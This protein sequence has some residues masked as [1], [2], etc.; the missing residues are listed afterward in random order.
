[1]VYEAESDLKSQIREKGADGK[2]GRDG[3]EGLVSD[4][5]GYLAYGPYVDKLALGTFRADF[6]LKVDNNTID[7]DV[8]KIDV[9]N[10][11]KDQVLAQ[12]TIKCTDFEKA[13]FTQIFSLYFNN[14]Q[15]NDVYEFRT[16]Y[17]GNSE[18]I[19]D[20]VSVSK[21]DKLLANEF[22]ADDMKMSEGCTKDG[23]QI[24][25][26]KSGDVVYGPYTNKITLGKNNAIFKVDISGEG[27]SDDV[28]AVFD[29]FT[30][31]ND[32]FFAKKELK[33]SEIVSDGCYHLTFDIPTEYVNSKI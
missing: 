28:V 9:Y 17:Y 16:Y 6:S 31:D 2:Y 4:N 3:I 22:T 24:K 33:R 1:M 11:T 8:L 12:Q 13:N 26:G 14:T 20:K 25:L 5:P 29:V 23:T 15:L 10:T 7:S 18:T 27:D 32:N 21:L 19:I 30:A